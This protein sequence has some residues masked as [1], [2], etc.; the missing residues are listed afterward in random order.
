MIV[1]FDS[2]LY[3]PPCGIEVET[4]TLEKR[5]ENYDSLFCTFHINAKGNLCTGNGVH[6]SYESFYEESDDI[7]NGGLLSSISRGI[8]SLFSTDGSTSFS[9]FIS[10]EA[11]VDLFRDSFKFMIVAFIFYL[12]MESIPGIIATLLSGV[13]LSFSGLGSG[14]MNII[15][16]RNAA[17]K[18]PSTLGSAAS[19]IGRIGRKNKK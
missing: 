6:G 15:N 9:A 7:D 12:M 14:S 18:I 1:T 3:P 4:C 13:N 11:I 19:R 5:C 10:F 16:M 8:Q 17:K 2:M